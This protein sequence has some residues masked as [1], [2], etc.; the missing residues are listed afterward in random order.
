[1][2]Q[3]LLQAPDE[4]GHEKAGHPAVHP[5]R[6]PRVEPFAEVIIEV[7]VDHRVAEA[8][9]QAPVV[10]HDVAIME[11]DGVHFGSAQDITEG[12]PDGLS[13]AGFA[14]META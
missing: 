12:H 5:V 6:H 3:H 4:R 13:L 1:M 7:R 8:G 14:R 10:T 9:E 2:T 11:R